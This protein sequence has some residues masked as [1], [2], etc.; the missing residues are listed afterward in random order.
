MNHWRVKLGISVC[1]D[2]KGKKIK[3]DKEREKQLIKDLFQKRLGCMPGQLK[4]WLL[5]LLVN[6]GFLVVYTR[7]MKLQKIK[8]LFGNFLKCFSLTKSQN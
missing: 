6:Q 8:I 2:T 4:K 7:M 3:L 5:H 1:N